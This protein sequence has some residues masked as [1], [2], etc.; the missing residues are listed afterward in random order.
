MALQEN[1]LMPR[2]SLGL[3]LFELMMEILMRTHLLQF[4]NQ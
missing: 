1:I 3:S 2:K 4:F